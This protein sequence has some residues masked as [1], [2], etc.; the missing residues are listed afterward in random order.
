MFPEP[1]GA[2]I[3][4][5]ASVPPDLTGA[6]MLSGS[7]SA[8]FGLFPTRTMAEEAAGSF[9]AFPGEVLIARTIGRRA[10]RTVWGALG[11]ETKEG[12]FS[13]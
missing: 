10:C 3:S 9:K 11:A 8:M 2:G 6:A 4:F 12:K 7:G 13:R 5:M 1:R